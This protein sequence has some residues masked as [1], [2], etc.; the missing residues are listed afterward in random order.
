MFVIL[1]TLIQTVAGTSCTLTREL[2]KMA[3]LI[4]RRW[5]KNMAWTLMYNQQW[6][7]S[8]ITTMTAGWI[9]TL[10]LTR[11]MNRTTLTY[12]GATGRKGKT[13]AWEGFTITIG[14]P[15]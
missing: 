2:I 10:L 1:F 11:L 12:L 8:L 6:P 7:L 3:C 14:T 15:A 5:P 9:C 4:L 13:P